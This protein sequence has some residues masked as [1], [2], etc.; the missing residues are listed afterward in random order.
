MR[1][2]LFLL[3]ALPVVA[4]AQDKTVISYNRVF[5]KQ[6]K[7]QPFEKALTQHAQKYHTGDVL[8][9]VSTIESG[10]DAGG[11][12]ITEGPTTWESMDK[13]GNLG[14]EHTRDWENNV[15]PLTT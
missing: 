3:V 11:Y 7:V 2:L 12:H 1:K 14:A 10:P 8:W 5:V 13:R 9:R 6:D 4:V 15:L